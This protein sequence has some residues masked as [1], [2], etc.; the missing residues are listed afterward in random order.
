[1]RILADESWLAS[2][3]VTRE[4]RIGAGRWPSAKGVIGLCRLRAARAMGV[5][6]ATSGARSDLDHNRR[7]NSTNRPLDRVID[8]VLSQ[9]GSSKAVMGLNAWLTRDWAD[10]RLGL[11][12]GV[13]RLSPKPI[14][15][16]KQLESTQANP[17][18]RVRLRRSTQAQDQSPSCSSRA[19]GWEDESRLRA[20]I[21]NPP[22]TQQRSTQFHT[23]L[24]SSG[25][26]GPSRTTT[27]PSTSTTTLSRTTR[28][29][30]S[31]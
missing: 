11:P 16:N 5:G 18:R 27:T 17:Y 10:V 9:G 19:Q 1:M 7:T 23:S 25:W 14:V 29:S 20:V 13:E 24:T 8:S 3:R 2:N 4:E 26:H 21:V 15:T 31:R 22:R 12:R 28:P 30:S 6:R